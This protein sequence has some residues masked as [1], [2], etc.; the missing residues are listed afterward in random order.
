M[1]SQ[2]ISDLTST[3]SKLYK[4]KTKGKI[5]SQDEKKA[6]VNVI[7][8]M[9]QVLYKDSNTNLTIQKKNL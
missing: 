2:K 4:D 5:V 6:I 1:S 3:G 9:L 7:V 8:D